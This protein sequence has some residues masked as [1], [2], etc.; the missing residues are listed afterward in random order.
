MKFGEWKTLAMHKLLLLY[1]KYKND[2]NIA[3]DLDVLIT[4]L[5]NLRARDLSSFLAYVH[6]VRRS[7]GLDELVSII[8]SESELKSI[9]E[10]GE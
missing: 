7:K 6:I 4:K 3:K 9:L 2:P 5:Q 10:E 8:P 1:D